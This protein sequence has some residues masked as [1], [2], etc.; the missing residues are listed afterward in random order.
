MSEAAA[1]ADGGKTKA[2]LK[3]ERKAKHEAERAAAAAADGGAADQTSK[4]DLRKQRREKQEA[5]RQAKAAAKE[6]ADTERARGGAPTS[7]AK[8]AAKPAP[9]SGGGGGGKDGKDGKG[10]EV[11][12]APVPR[13]ERRSPKA[14]ER[15]QVVS[16]HPE[17]GRTASRLQSLEILGAN[18]RAVALVQLLRILVK[19]AEVET[20]PRQEPSREHTRAVEKTLV[21][22]LQ[23]TITKAVGYLES[24]RKLS[25]SMQNV[26][27]I[28]ESQLLRIPDSLA[29]AEVRKRI[30]LVLKGVVEHSIVAA[31]K[32]IAHRCVDG[33][34]TSSAVG[35]SSNSLARADPKL[36]D[37]DV[38]LTFGRSTAVEWTFRLA[39]HRGVNFEVVV[40]DSRPLYEG[41]QFVLD[42]AG[43]GVRCTYCLLNSLA[44]VLQRCNKVFVGASTML[45]NGSLV[46][47]MGTAVVCTMAKDFKLPVL[48]LCETYKL[49]DKVWLRDLSLHQNLQQPS[50]SVVRILPGQ[51]CEK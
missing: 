14:G 28:V 1:P 36:K 47:R 19:E 42:L 40:V 51:L 34:D 13:S 5:E 22:V 9:K 12:K 8:P 31:G 24:K 4:A 46:S 7:A 2:E 44:N 26:V 49:T 27:S 10:K 29:N 21:Q 43:L 20:S 30:D 45:S 17:L 37:G 18:A 50:T 35:V 25:Q 15:R 6:K 39:K 48:S 33:S 38:V 16:V 32:S 23:E 41:R 11:K 3:A